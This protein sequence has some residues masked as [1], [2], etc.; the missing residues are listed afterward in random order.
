MEK[1]AVSKDEVLTCCKP[2]RQASRNHAAALLGPPSSFQ[3]TAANSSKAIGTL[4]HIEEAEITNGLHMYDIPDVWLTPTQHD[5]LFEVKVDGLAEKRPS[6]MRGDTIRAIDAFGNVHIG[7]AHYVNADN[8]VISFDRNSVNLHTSYLIEFTIKRVEFQ[9]QHR[10]LSHGSVFLDEPTALAPPP[11]RGA[12]VTPDPTHIAT[13]NE[14]QRGFVNFALNSGRLVNILWGPPGTGKT[15][16][17]VRYIQALLATLQQPDRLRKVVVCTP[18][19]ASADNLCVGLHKLG[20]R[21]ILRVVS[22]SRLHG[23][24]PESIRQYALPAGWGEHALKDGHVPPTERQIRDADVIVVTLGSMGRLYGMHPTMRCSHFIVDEAGQATEAEMG[25][26]LVICDKDTSRIVLAGD[27][28][29]LGPVTQSN[30]A[31]QYGFNVSPLERLLNM[32]DVKKHCCHMLKINY[33]SHPSIL[34]IVNLHYDNILRSPDDLSQGKFINGPLNF[35]GS[36]AQRIR[37]LHASGPESQEPDSPSIMNSGEIVEVVKM[38]ESLL[39][40]ESPRS[41]VVLTPYLKQAQKIRNRIHSAFVQTGIVS[42]G[43]IEVCTIEA[44]QGREAKNIIISCVRSRANLDMI[45]KDIQ[46][47]LGF[48]KQPQRANVAISRA[49]DRLWIV[50]NWNLLEHDDV[51]RRLMWHARFMLNVEVEPCNG[52]PFVHTVPQP[53]EEVGD[54]VDDDGDGGEGAAQR[55]E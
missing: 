53:F 25:L 47:H 14:A 18:S 30:V 29:Q 6:V 27:P 20:L 2:L 33:R 8:V 26:G 52:I 48:L 38:I 36:R 12:T 15:T 24:L 54:D 55:L 34:S 28:K 37:L 5:G 32:A 45:K 31:K 50:G 22:F 19:N 41:I 43:T 9:L 7:Y 46:R 17:L 23:Q 39:K 21:K 1:I 49:I 40:S 11:R 51:W 35:T 10:A 4:L 13:L 44:F 42:S 3:L 16:T